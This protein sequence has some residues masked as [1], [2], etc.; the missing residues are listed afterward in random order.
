MSDN[1]KAQ[2]AAVVQSGI[3]HQLHRLGN[4]TEALK[5]AASGLAASIDAGEQP[6]ALQIDALFGLLLDELA[7]TQTQLDRLTH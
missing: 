1:R 5:L 3:A 6:E 2:M 4:V 7:D